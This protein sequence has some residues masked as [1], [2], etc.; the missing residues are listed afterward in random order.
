MI[1]V[2][3]GGPAATSGKLA[4]N[5]RITAVGEGKTGELVDVIG[6][7]LD[8][9]VQKIRGPGGTMVRLQLLPAGAAPGSPQKVVEFTR[10]RVS[11]EAQA[12]AQ[13]HARGAAQRPRREGRHHHGAELLS[14]L[15]CQP[16][17]REGLPQHDARCAAPDRRTEARTAPT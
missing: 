10:N 1:D 13:G 5:D 16:R 8:D 9:V 6:W 11:L 2:I 12:C 17:R 3:A 7:R 4:A 14:G 15:R